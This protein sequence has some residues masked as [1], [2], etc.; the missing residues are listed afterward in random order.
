[1][2]TLKEIRRRLQAIDNIKQITKSM[3]MIAAARFQRAHTR[4]I[5]AEK[6]VQEMRSIMSHVKNAYREMSPY[7]KQQKEAPTL[8]MI[9][10]ADR[11]LCGA[12]NSNLFHASDSLL[13]EY[14]PNQLELMV[15]GK[16]TIEYYE[17]KQWPIR[18]TLSDWNEKVKLSTITKIA[19]EITEQFLSGAYASIQLIYTHH[20][21][22]FSRQV[23]KATLLP[24]E[25]APQK[26]PQEKSKKESKIPQDY[27]FEPQ[28]EELFVKLLPK[29]CFAEV[30]HMFNQAY[31]SEL[32]ARVC[33]MQFATKNAE[34]IKEN[35]TLER[36]K[37]R[38]TSIT[39][40]VLEISLGAE[41]S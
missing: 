25:T 33:A 1:M 10:G 8:I 7:S 21:T 31:T 3:E 14:S 27:I 18:Q 15:F 13:R 4:T 34:E 40:E 17:K 35:L 16:K 6:Y 37:L 24:I 32:A 30:Y 11:G 39:K 9:A 29:Y 5:H 41:H 19:D 38:Q 20:Q 22:I 23:I 12:Y 2:A 28:I 26:E 36:N